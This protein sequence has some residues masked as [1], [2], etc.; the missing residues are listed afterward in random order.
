MALSVKVKEVIFLLS[1]YSLKIQHVNS[2][3]KKIQQVLEAAEKTL[4][5]IYQTC[6]RPKMGV[7][8][9]MHR[10]VFINLNMGIGYA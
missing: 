3:M 2:E 4:A 9:S 10:L 5:L 7:R 6:V 8:L 1:I